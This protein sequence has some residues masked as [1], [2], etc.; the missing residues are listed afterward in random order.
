[1]AHYSINAWLQSMHT[2]AGQ[3]ECLTC[4][5]V[6]LLDLM[7][8]NGRA[9]PLR[10]RLQRIFPFV[11]NFITPTSDNYT[12]NYQQLTLT[13]SRTYAVVV[14]NWL[15]FKSTDRTQSHTTT[16]AMSEHVYNTSTL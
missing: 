11:H 6:R 13:E 3:A 15:N 9:L 1:M 8:A 4:V 7:H 16:P 10:A 14:S 5:R 2:Q 12:I